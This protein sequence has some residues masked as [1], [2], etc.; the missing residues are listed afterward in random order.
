MKKLIRG[1]HE[2]HKKI[3]SN[4]KNFYQG[5]A[6]GQSPEVLFITCSDSRLNPNQLTQ[7]DPGDLFILRNAGNIIPAYGSGSGAE[8]ATIEFGILGL[9]IKH[10]IVCGHSHCGA[11]K[12][13]MNPKI[14]ENLPAVR[15]WLQNAAHTKR[16]VED[17]YPGFDEDYIL[18]IT[19]QENVLC[20]IENLKTH[21]A[22]ASRLAQGTISIHA[23][24]HKF[25]TGEV[26]SYVPDEGQFL[27]LKQESHPLPHRKAL[28]T[29]T[30]SIQKTLN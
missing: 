4:N 21:P 3:Y 23:W 8:A 25:E 19:I 2:F 7:T 9:G 22:V 6:N 15:D 10:I 20:Q 24:V 28:N 27:P 5:L 17:N 16:V 29:E 13:L 30:R 26:F 1:I 14:T 12:G 11:M 18:N